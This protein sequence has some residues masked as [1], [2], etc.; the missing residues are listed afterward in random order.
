MGLRVRTHIWGFLKIFWEVP[1]TMSNGM[2]GN[3][4]KGQTGWEMEGGMTTLKGPKNREDID[5]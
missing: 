1:N 2:M 4:A 3:L 5:E